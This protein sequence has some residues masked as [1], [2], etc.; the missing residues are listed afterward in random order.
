MAVPCTFLQCIGKALLERCGRDLD[1]DFS[2]E[3]LSA[4]GQALWHDWASQGDE[5]EKTDELD[6]LLPAPPGALGRTVG[7]IASGLCADQPAAGRRALEGY[8]RQVP[9]TV[10]RFLRRP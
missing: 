2:A 9:A 7:G 4:I 1:G 6:K 8:L 10:R 3:A 5:D